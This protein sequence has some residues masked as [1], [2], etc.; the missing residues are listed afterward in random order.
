MENNVVMQLFIQRHL[1]D[2]RSLTVPCTIEVLSEKDEKL[3]IELHNDVASG[4]SR[5]LFAASTKEELRRFL[6]KDGIAVGA[7]SGGR[8]V[9]LRTLKISPDWV[10]ESLADYNL[11]PETYRHSAVTGFCVVDREFRGN[12]IQFLTQFYAENIVSRSFDSVITTVSPKNIFSLQNV[13]AC[14]YHIIAIEWIYGGYLRFVLKKEFRPI[15]PLWTHG[16]LRIPIRDIKRQKQ[17]LSNGCV[18]YKIIRGPSGFAILYGRVG[19]TS[20]P[21]GQKTARGK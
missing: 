18:G 19:P 21:A 12:N 2:G 11:S 7:R 16:H 1:P 10:R 13:L 8:L 17:A 3:S 5:D 15:D 20:S 6:T 14:G 9:C 4:L